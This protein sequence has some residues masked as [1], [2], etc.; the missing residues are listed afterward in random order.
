MTIVGRTGKLLYAI[1][2]GVFAVA[3]V[4]GVIQSL[5]VERRVPAIDLFVSGSKTYINE[6]LDR[7][8]FDGAIRQLKMQTRYL[9]F[10]AAT[11]EDLGILL[12]NQAR[13]EQARAQFEE[14]VRLR[15]DYAEGYNLLGSTYLDTDQPALA[16]RYFSEA[17][18]LNPEFPLAFNSLG[19]AYA[20]LGRLT[21]AEQCFA[22][23][24]ELAPVN[25]DAR[26]NLDRA[27]KELGLEL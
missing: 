25:K 27:R 10:D 23:A 24:V 17:V 19:V 20:R 14:L 18:R 12:G 6:L 22:K 7:K 9:P 21:E 3:L 11:R 8:D 13:P 1:G 15:P 16:A 26:I 5:R 4:A 2:V